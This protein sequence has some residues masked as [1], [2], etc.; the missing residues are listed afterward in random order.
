M[1][2]YGRYDKNSTNEAVEYVAQQVTG[3][4]AERVGHGAYTMINLESPSEL[5]K[6][7]EAYLSQSLH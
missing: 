1:A 3:A 5:N 2:A 4:E 6:W 7:L